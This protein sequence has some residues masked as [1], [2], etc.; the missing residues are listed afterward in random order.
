MDTFLQDSSYKTNCNS[1][2][3][4]KIKI[5]HYI[6]AEFWAFADKYRLKI[7]AQKWNIW[8]DWWAGLEEMKL[9]IGA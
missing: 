6:G 4:I 1:Q 9:E 3:E 8:E 7:T 5:K 2:E